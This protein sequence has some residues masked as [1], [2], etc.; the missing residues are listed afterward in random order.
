MTGVMVG[1]V[2]A[3]GQNVA[4]GGQ[5]DYLCYYG[6]T[7]GDMNKGYNITLVGKIS[8]KNYATWHNY[9][10]WHNYAI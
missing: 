8:R 3:V 9:A 2:G 10:V 6:Q 7:V 5:N 1:G 4:E